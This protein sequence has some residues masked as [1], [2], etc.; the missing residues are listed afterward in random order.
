[1]K[2]SAIR[3]V[4][5][6]APCGV[7]LATG[8]QAQV[9]VDPRNPPAL[10]EIVVTATKRAETLI[11]V[12]VAVTA[13]TADQMQA[14]GFNDYADYL[15]TIPNV[16]M[17]DVGPG[18]TQLY[19]RGLVAQGGSGFPVATY[20]GEAVT[21]VVTNNGGFADLR[22]VDIDRVEVLRGPQ[23]TLFGANS[24]A[25][26]L[27]IVPA[28]PNLTEVQINTDVRGWSTSHSDDFS[29]H[30]DGV[31]NLPIVTDKL[32]V[33]VVAYKDHIAGYI[34]NIV[35][36]AAPLD[37]SDSV[38]A[39][40]GTLVIPGHAAFTRE[41]INSE[42][43]WGA[44]IAVSWKPID[45]LRIDVNYA[46]QG[47]RLNSEPPIQPA[48]GDYNIQRP[49][50][51]YERGKSTEDLRVGS[52]VVNYDWANATL[53]SASSYTDMRRYA[54]QDIAWLA[55]SVGLGEQL[56]ALQDRSK[57]TEFTQ[58]VRLQS[59]GES[60]W[61]WLAGYFYS[62]S[63]NDLGQSV[64]DYSC[65]TCLPEVLAG[66][67]F[68]LQ[69][70]GTPISAKQKQQSVFG[71]VS[72]DFTSQW[73]LG[74]GGRYLKDYIES[75]NLPGD[76]ILGGGPATATGPNGGGETS[77]FNP[78]GYIRYKPTHDMMY[79]LQAARG[80]RSG[81]TN[82]SLSFD[83]NGPCAETAAQL[84]L[85]PLSAPDKLWTYELGLKSAW[86]DN[87]VAT[88][89]AIFHQKWDG[90]Q[91]ATSQACGFQGVVNGGD[92]SGNGA[93]LE[94]TAKITAPLSV[95]LSASWV[96]NKFD[97]VVPNLGYSDGDRVPG[98][99]EENVSA[100]LQYDFVLHGHWSGD[101]RGDY[102][103]VGNV[104]YQFGQGGGA[105]E[106]VQGGYG[107]GNLRVALRHDTLS[108]E[109]FGRNITDKRAAEA[110]GDP[111][112]GGYVYLLRPREVGLEL[113]YSFNR[114]R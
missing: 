4:S 82:Q 97:S 42:D 35:P 77:I 108:I 71:D 9:G 5:G 2:Q 107:Q 84:G 32:G 31:L 47:V 99:P 94:V 104:H 39:P 15:N 27:R 109:L 102:V 87:R 90:V 100:G 83:P 61:Q 44:R 40:A 64:P 78:S 92:A 105:E 56:W 34:D 76:G 21:S 111:A 73:T 85:G 106:F 93:E 98:A 51:Q 13:I 41:D 70:A 33:R 112:N 55:E 88:N 11:D 28:A 48:H 67:S 59:R 30:A 36:A 69:T 29:G 14:R 66:Q 10:E 26:V 16:W 89:L 110:T 53:T 19:I 68:A 75:F 113:R 3:L 18:Q 65:P 103:Y 95:N 17:Q 38:G 60:P 45:A 54:S 114:A 101:V 1:M 81:S 80:F 74:V 6:L 58:E 43:V 12:P 50:D 7:L 72:Y 52:F 20:F 22:L 8:A 63:Q 23:G 79:Y 46:Q 57:G 96:H 49:L 91:L 25:G 86:L 62:N 24:L 37:Y